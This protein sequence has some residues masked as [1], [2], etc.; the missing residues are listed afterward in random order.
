[1]SARLEVTPF[2]AQQAEG[3]RARAVYSSGTPS[4][5]CNWCD[6]A[7]VAY[8]SIPGERPSKACSGHL[9]KL[10][11]LAVLRAMELGL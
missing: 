1:M 7:M 4:A 3:I 10:V 8:I 11:P 2:P 6:R 9:E 5:V